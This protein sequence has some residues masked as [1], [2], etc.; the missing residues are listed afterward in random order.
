MG[1]A[2]DRG[3]C[4]AKDAA[5]EQC[6][7]GADGDDD[8]AL[9]LDPFSEDGAPSTLE[10]PLAAELVRKRHLAGFAAAKGEVAPLPVQV[11][12]AIAPRSLAK[13][14]PTQPLDLRSLASARSASP[15]V[16]RLASPQ[17]CHGR[18]T[19]LSFTPALPAL[20]RP[21]ATISF[22]NSPFTSSLQS[23]PTI[24]EV[25]DSRMVAPGISPQS[26][27]GPPPSI[28]QLQDVRAIAQIPQ[29]SQ[30]APTAA[31]NA[32]VEESD[33][34]SIPRAPPRLQSSSPQ[35]RVPPQAPQRI[36]VPHERAPRPQPRRPGE[37]SKEQQSLQQVNSITNDADSGAGA[38]RLLGW[39]EIE[40]AKLP[41]ESET[42]VLVDLPSLI[43]KA[44]GN[45]QSFDSAALEAL[46]KAYPQLEF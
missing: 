25:R 20:S 3:N 22:S 30:A 43:R 19:V 26:Q 7:C 35:G 28:S 44:Q 42:P 40:A 6:A 31:C 14:R 9:R 5:C 17:R 2:L 46:D 33:A 21:T 15:A 13:P 29:Q 24:S 12:P 27:A 36:A 11:F 41:G 16:H 34:D 4:S 37:A 38:S 1:S 8:E 23:S 45:R 18:S 10:E 39:S 32:I